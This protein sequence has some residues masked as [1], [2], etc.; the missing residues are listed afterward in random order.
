MGNSQLWSPTKLIHDL[1]KQLIGTTVINWVASIGWMNIQDISSF[2]H[3]KFLALSQASH[4]D[5]VAS[6][7]K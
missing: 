5:Y 3:C 4:G 1:A 7:V 2:F 6:V